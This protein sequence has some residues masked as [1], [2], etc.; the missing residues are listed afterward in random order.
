MD[1][2]YLYCIRSLWVPYFKYEFSTFAV[3]WAL[4]RLNLPNHLPDSPRVS[5]E[6]KGSPPQDVF[7]WEMFHLA[8]LVLSFFNFLRV[9]GCSV[10]SPQPLWGPVWFCLPPNYCDFSCRMFR[11]LLLRWLTSF[12][13]TLLLFPS[14]FMSA[15]EQLR[16][17]LSKH[18]L[19]FEICQVLNV[20]NGDVSV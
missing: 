12:Q 10:L 6:M 2:F 15:W 14:S 11:I 4:L 9:S 18:S 19:H 7:L 8:N 3:V 17:L 1:N 13:L 20:Q 16:W 5:N